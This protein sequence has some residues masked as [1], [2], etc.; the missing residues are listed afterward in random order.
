VIGG[1]ANEQVR[2]ARLVRKAK[3]LRATQDTKALSPTRALRADE[4]VALIHV[5]EVEK[6]RVEKESNVTC[7][8]PPETTHPQAALL[9]YSG[10]PSQF[11]EIVD[12]LRPTHGVHG[13]D[14]RQIKLGAFKTRPASHEVPA[15]TPI[16]APTPVPAPIPA[17]P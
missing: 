7:A 9:S 4:C 14:P 13:H 3:S 10:D 12:S 16:P 5:Y 15:L 6:I 1:E 2:R 17:S 11:E 8:F